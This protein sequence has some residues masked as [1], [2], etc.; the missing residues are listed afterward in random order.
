M[1]YIRN[2]RHDLWVLLKFRFLF[3]SKRQ[4]EKSISGCNSRF[5]LRSWK[6][7]FSAV[8]RKLPVYQKF[9]PGFYIPIILKS[10]SFSHAFTVVCPTPVWTAIWAMVNPALRAS[11]TAIPLFFA[12]LLDNFSRSFC[13]ML[14][15]DKKNSFWAKK[16]IYSKKILT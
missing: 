1:Q 14:W 10:V 15:R 9:A 8:V 7:R 11:I 5:V 6:I 12:V 16:V 3:P 4:S 13:L 2:F